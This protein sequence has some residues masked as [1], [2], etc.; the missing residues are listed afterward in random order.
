[1]ANRMT[2]QFL[3]QLLRLK[4]KLNKNPSKKERKDYTINKN[5]DKMRHK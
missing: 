3:K 1:M 4:Q 5:K 2:K